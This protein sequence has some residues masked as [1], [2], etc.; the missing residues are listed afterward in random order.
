MSALVIAG[1]GHHGRQARQPRRVVVLRVGG[2][3]RGAR[4]PARPPARARRGA[5]HRGR[6]HLLLR[7]G[8]PPVVPAH[9]RRAHASWASGRPST[10]SGRSPTP[11]SRGPPRSASPTRGWRR[12]WPGVLA[13]RGASA[14]VFRGEDGLDEI[15]PTGPTR[16]W[17]VRDGGV[18][19]SVIDWETDLG[20]ARID[21]R[22]AARREGGL[23]RR[24]RA[25][26]ARRRDRAR[27]RDR[28][29][30]HGR[31]ARGR[32]HACPAPR[33]H[34]RRAA[35]RAG[36]GARGVRP[37]DSGAR[38]ATCSAPLG[39]TRSAVSCGR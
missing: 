12:S 24:R 11:P 27:A 19:E 26:A 20:V 23:Q 6:H 17:E 13:G 15:A 18:T 31:R 37:L 38:R 5:R 3:A 7:A 14:L 2:R 28:R 4:H 10:S 25:A 33:R 36:S 32:R 16:I 9:R 30:Q 1:A 35:W 22:V 29:A 8:V 34:A 39:G 21:A